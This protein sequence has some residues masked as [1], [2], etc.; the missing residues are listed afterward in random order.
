MFTMNKNKTS[1]KLCKDCKWF[2]YT[3]FHEL[4]L[5][6]VGI[7]TR[8]RRPEKKK[9]NIYGNHTVYLDLPIVL[10][11]ET[12]GIGADC[13][14]DGRFWQPTASFKIKTFLRRI[15]LWRRSSK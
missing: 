3:P 14:E 5:F 13:G 4:D 10:G 11:R 2:V 8:C 12:S 7:S 15:F 9:D 6:E 1:N